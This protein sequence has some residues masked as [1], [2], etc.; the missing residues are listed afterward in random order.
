MLKRLLSEI[1]GKKV[2]S[3]VA[4]ELPSAPS[5]RRTSI[6]FPVEPGEAP[7]GLHAVPL[8]DVTVVIPTVAH[9]AHHMRAALQH[10]SDCA[11]SAQI[12]VSDHS[13]SNQLGVIA[14]LVKSFPTLNIRILQHDPSLHFL[15][16]LSDCAERSSTP[17]VVVHADDDFM[18]PDALHE[19][20]EF[21]NQN[22]DFVA[23]QGRI[24]F[25]RLERPRKSTP[26]PQRLLSRIESTAADRLAAHCANF[27]PTLYALTRREAFAKANRQALRYTDNV[28]FWQYLSSCNL[29]S[30]GK[31]GILDW[32]YYLRLDNP[33]GWRATLVR[34]GDPTHWPYLIAAP[35]FS[36]ELGRFK[37]GLAACMDQIAERDR[38]ID[39][40][41]IGLIQRAFSKGTVHEAAEFALQTQLLEEG[42]RATAILRYASALCC[43]RLGRSQNL[44]RP[45]CFAVVR[46]LTPDRHQRARQGGAVNAQQGVLA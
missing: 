25:F 43:T 2:T 4:P 34:E 45:A 6:N 33:N 27:T 23:C 41:C 30:L 11:L 1:S 3:P 26:S 36:S 5:G 38:V 28:I 37:Q 15:E 29:V 39:K 19:C 32:L 13:E 31:L 44:T 12:V 14:E 40:A 21:L 10:L 7:Q 24:F 18:M 16:R 9:R 8:A 17:Y 20:E 42:N 35:D 22:P 46:E